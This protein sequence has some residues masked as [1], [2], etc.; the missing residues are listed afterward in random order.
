MFVVV[1]RRV[2]TTA[3][4]LLAEGAGL[5]EGLLEKA[6]KPV[7]VV[8]LDG[9]APWRWRRRRRLSNAKAIADN[10]TRCSKEHSVIVVLKGWRG[11]RGAAILI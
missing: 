1:N 11:G 8:L 10:P 9:H 2:V 7:T 5:A 4:D 6:A 3:E